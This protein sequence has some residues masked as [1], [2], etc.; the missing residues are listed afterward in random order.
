MQNRHEQDRPGPGSYEVEKQES[1]IDRQFS[2][3][4][5]FAKTTG[6]NL[7]SQLNTEQSISDSE[8]LKEG[9][10]VSFQGVAQSDLANAMNSMMS[11]LQKQ[12]RS[13]SSL[14]NDSNLGPGSYF[15]QDRKQAVLQ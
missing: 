11:Q 7:A 2:L 5:Q 9:V 3:R 1:A 14:R 4:Q 15:K 6:R 8:A 12:S 10:M 13:Q